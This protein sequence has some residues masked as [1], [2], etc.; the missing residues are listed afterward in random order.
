MVSGFS[1]Q[2]ILFLSVSWGWGEV[3]RIYSTV[4]KGRRLFPASRPHRK[5]QPT[6]G[7]RN[8]SEELTAVGLCTLSNAFTEQWLH[9]SCVDLVCFCHLWAI[10]GISCQSPVHWEWYWIYLLLLCML[11]GCT[12]SSGLL[13]FDRKS[14]EDW[15]M[16][17]INQWKRFGEQLVHFIF[18]PYYSLIFSCYFLVF[19]GY[20]YGYVQ[21]HC[22]PRY[23]LSSPKVFNII[24][25]TCHV[26]QALI[27][28]IVYILYCILL[29]LMSQ[30]GL[31]LS[32]YVTK[33]HIVHMC[34]CVYLCG[35]MFYT[36]CREGHLFFVPMRKSANLP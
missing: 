28:K 4:S 9:T 24:R 21:L 32:C 19:A 18:S 5:S 26:Q 1:N 31:W 22:L 35:N 2:A 30:P 27:H 33:Q 15:D 36:L 12:R 7:K 25:I 11:R 20:V 10:L 6:E 23:Q 29:C 3:N 16:Q 17:F 34:V 8:D 14:Q 13:L